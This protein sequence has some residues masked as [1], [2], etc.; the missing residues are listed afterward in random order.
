LLD[1][2]VVQHHSCVGGN[3]TITETG[4]YLL[5]QVGIVGENSS[6]SYTLYFFNLNMQPRH[7]RITTWTKKRMWLLWK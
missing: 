6:I 1:P 7:E 2:V 4:E 5:L 3:N